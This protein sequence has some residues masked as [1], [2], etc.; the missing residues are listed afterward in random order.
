MSGTTIATTLVISTT[1]QNSYHWAPENTGLCMFAVAVGS[2]LTFPITG[3]FGDHV[4][5][6]LGKRAQTGHR[7]SQRILLFFWQTGNIDSLMPNCDRSLNT[8]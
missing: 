4:Q 3:I 6:V 2:I 7:V 8:N 1:L 5:K